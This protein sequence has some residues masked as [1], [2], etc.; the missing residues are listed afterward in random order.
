VPWNGI[1]AKKKLTHARGKE[2]K[3]NGGRTGRSARRQEVVRSFRGLFERPE[4]AL[5]GTK[6]SGRRHGQQGKGSQD[7]VEDGGRRSFGYFKR[8]GLAFLS[9]SSRIQ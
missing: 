6:P 5:V 9:F 7:G 3:G 4:T 8:H 1:C 2:A